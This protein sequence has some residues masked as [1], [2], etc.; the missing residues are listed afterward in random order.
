MK[1]LE[2]LNKLSDYEINCAVAEKLGLEIYTGFKYGDG[3]VCVKADVGYKSSSPP[4]SVRDY[5]NNPN[6]YMPIAEKY[7][8]DIEFDDIGGRI[9]VCGYWED[10]ARKSWVSAKSNRKT[11]KSVGTAFLMMDN[12][13]NV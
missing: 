11:G 10:K 5:C 8:I 2:Q 3:S 13:V 7:L 6:D 1:T 12:E 9:A 4:F